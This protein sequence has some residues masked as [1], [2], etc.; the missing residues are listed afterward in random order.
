MRLPTPLT[1]FALSFKLSS[2]RKSHS[3]A[4][5]R[6]NY[7]AMK[8]RGIDS[9]SQSG[10][11]SLHDQ[12]DRQRE[13]M[14][15]RRQEIDNQPDGSSLCTSRSRQRCALQPPSN[16][17]PNDGKRSLAPS[18]LGHTGPLF[19]AL[20]DYRA[21]SKEDLSFRKG[22]LLYIVDTAD[23]DWWLARSVEGGREGSVP[24]N[25]VAEART[26]DAEE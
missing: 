16:P 1:P 25:Y 3:S 13:R 26:I 17:N 11:P 20:Y 10:G 4:S 23:G 15:Q 2:P 12:L 21:G 14:R 19:K 9:S 8:R 7:G 18:P 24:R 6:K 5:N 22:E